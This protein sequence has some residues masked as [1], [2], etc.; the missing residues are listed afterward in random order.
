MSSRPELKLDWC[1]FKAA[2][3]ACEHWHYSRSMPTPPYNLVGAWEDGAFIG[4]VVFSRGAAR[5][6]PAEYGLTHEQFCELTRVA[7]SA[8]R[9]PVSRIIAIAL[10]MLKARSPG[11][12][13]VVSFAD[14]NQ[15]HHGGIYQAG[16]WV[17]C[18]QRDDTTEFIGPDGKQWHS[19]MISPTGTKLVY[20]KRRP[21]WRPDQCKAVKLAGKL[22]YLMPLDSETRSLIEPLRQQYTKRAGSVL[23]G[24]PGDQLGGGGA[25]PTPALS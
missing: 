16:G 23:D 4:V 21:V 13:L 3:W 22:K 15:G 9:T 2:K 11:I 7:L 18:G 5:H 6:G 1:D 20:G 19:R 24:T 8:H 14:P 10:R 12:R 25:I 17:F